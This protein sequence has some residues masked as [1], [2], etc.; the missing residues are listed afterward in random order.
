MMPALLNNYWICSA[1]CEDGPVPVKVLFNVHSTVLHRFATKTPPDALLVTKSATHSTK[2]TTVEPLGAPRCEYCSAPALWQDDD[3]QPVRRVP[4]LTAE[5]LHQ[6]NPSDP[7]VQF[8]G[9]YPPEGLVAELIDN[10]W[11]RPEWY[12]AD[13]RFPDDIDLSGIETDTFELPPIY[14]G[15]TYVDRTECDDQVLALRTICTAWGIPLAGP[16]RRTLAESM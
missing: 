16:R 13:L 9:A 14:D 7:F 6:H 10:G 8:S 2:S 5:L 11:A 3:T 12:S 1:G 15:N 4:N